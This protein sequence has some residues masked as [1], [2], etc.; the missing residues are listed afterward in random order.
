MVGPGCYVYKPR[1]VP[2]TFWNPGPGPA[3]L[4]ELIWPAGFERFFE[5]LA[6]LVRAPHPDLWERWVELGLEYG[7]E[8]VPEW[9]PQLQAQRG[10]RLVGPE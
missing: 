7:L 4:V 10:L 3:R 9:I 2:R 6:E 8:F 5:Q 1:G